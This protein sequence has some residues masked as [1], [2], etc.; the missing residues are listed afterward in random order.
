VCVV[1]NGSKNWLIIITAGQMAENRVFS[2]SDGIN[3]DQ[4][5]SFPRAIKI[6]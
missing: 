2:R 4:P 5:I 3:Y 1:M 6:T